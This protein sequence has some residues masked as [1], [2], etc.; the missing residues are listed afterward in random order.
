MHTTVHRLLLR[1]PALDTVGLPL[2]GRIMAGGASGS[3][4]NSKSGGGGVK[5]AAAVMAERQWLMRLLWLG[6][7]V[8]W[9]ASVCNSNCSSCIAVTTSCGCYNV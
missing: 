8:S 9:C 6:L 5:G 1:Q 7:R 4:S 2:F 3:N